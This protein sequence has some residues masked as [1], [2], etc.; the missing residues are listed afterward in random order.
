MDECDRL[1]TVAGMVMEDHNLMAVSR[2]KNPDDRGSPSLRL[3]QRLEA[4]YQ[5]WW[6]LR[7]CSCASADFPLPRVITVIEAHSEIVTKKLYEFHADDPV[8]I[9]RAQIRRHCEGLD[10]TTSLRTAARRQGS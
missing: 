8:S 1:C 4:I 7:R 5:S 2:S 3:S 10:F 6:T 9:V